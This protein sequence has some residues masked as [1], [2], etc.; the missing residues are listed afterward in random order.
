MSIFTKATKSSVYLKIAITGP[1]GSAKTF[2]ALRLAKGLSKA[3]KVCLIDTENR[4]ASLYADKFNF[5][6]C[7]IDRPFSDSKF[8]DAI[9]AA[10]NEKYSVV[11][12][13]SW[14]HSWEGILEWKAALDSRGGNSYVNW[15]IAGKKF[16]AILGAVLQ[17]N[18]HV[19][20]CMRSKMDYILELNLEGKQV[21]KKVGMAPIMRDGIEYEFVTVFDAQA[22]HEVTTSKDRT[23]LFTDQKFQIT[24]AT[25]QKFLD[26]MADHEVTTSKDGTGLFTDQKFQI[27]EATGQKFL[28]WMADLPTQ[29]LTA[30]VTM[31][32]TASARPMQGSDITAAIEK[33]TSF[34]DS[35]GQPLDPVVA[36]EQIIADGAPPLENQA[37]PINHDIVIIEQLE[38]LIG[39]YEPLATEYFLK[40]FYIKKGQT[41]RDTDPVRIARM[42]KNPEP[43]LQVL[44]KQYEDSKAGTEDTKV[45]RPF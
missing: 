16:Q 24:E 34:S 14:S 31:P 25:G 5:D 2:S 20:A 23:G 40:K 37:T 26:W 44:K 18:I 32:A 38:K 17:T 33:P 6:T 1:S 29:V 11:I 8:I 13:D 27:T 35:L 45:E 9:N 7:V 36:A 41:F 3:G 22:D 19:I 15:G 42:L 21:P 28:D 43:L 30:A 12:I 4:S 39:K 10:V